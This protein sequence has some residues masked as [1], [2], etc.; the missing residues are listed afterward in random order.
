MDS[1][2][3]A[4]LPPASRRAAPR[5]ALP[6][7][8]ILCAFLATTGCR[9]HD[10]WT[11]Q[12]GKA[13]WYGDQFHGRQTASGEQFNMTALTAAHPTLE[14]GS[15]VRVTNE[16]NGRK[17]LVRINDRFQSKR[18]RVIDLSKAAFEQLAPLNQGVIDVHLEVTAR[19]KKPK[20][21]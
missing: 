21:R 19:P 18:G 10:H 2:S 20:R 9:R 4:A 5:V 6:L 12:R 8:L 15:L 7:A 14:F 3:F 11:E 17:V 1:L 16:A 13:S